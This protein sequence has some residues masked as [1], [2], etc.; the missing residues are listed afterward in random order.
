MSG[1][2]VRKSDVRE[3]T[4]FKSWVVCQPL[5]PLGIPPVHSST[6]KR[7]RGLAPLL[8]PGCAVDL[9]LPQEPA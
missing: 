6:L 7:P 4:A 8:L 3:W 1:L 2:I 5:A 9:P